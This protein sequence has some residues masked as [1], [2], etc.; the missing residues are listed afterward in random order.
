MYSIKQITSQETFAVRLPVLRPGKPIDSCIFDGDDLNTT[1]HFGIYDDEI[2]VGVT[3]IFQTSTPLLSQ[4]QQFQLRGM[5][6][7]D[8]HQKRGLGDQLV[9][10]AEQYVKENNAEVLWFNAREI[11]VGFYKKMGYETIGEPFAIGDIG[12]HYVMYKP[13]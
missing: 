5:A 4:K 10:R 12:I 11:A 6:I 7:V 9:Q 3:S 2:I 13:L 8:S 1:A